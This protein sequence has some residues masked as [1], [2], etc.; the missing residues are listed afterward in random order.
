MLCISHDLYRL[1]GLFDNTIN[2]ICHQIHAYMKS[3][4]E[5]YTYFQMLQHED[6]KHF[7]HTMEIKI[8]DHET[9]KH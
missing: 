1:N 4:N 3:D 9:H 8:D 7:F 2:N 6:Y 5:S